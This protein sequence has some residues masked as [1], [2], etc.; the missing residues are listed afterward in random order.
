MCVRVQCKLE[1]TLQLHDRSGFKRFPKLGVSQIQK[2][3]DEEGWREE[4][5]PFERA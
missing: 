5:E 3:R 1:E 4:E 2:V